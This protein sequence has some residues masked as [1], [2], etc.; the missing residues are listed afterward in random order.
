MNG[1]KLGGAG[2]GVSLNCVTGR[3]RGA[4]KWKR[5]RRGGGES[6]LLGG[7]GNRGWD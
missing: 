1:V 5:K 4:V 7:E 6:R 2:S 3:V